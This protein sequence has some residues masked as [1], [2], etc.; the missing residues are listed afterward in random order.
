MTKTIKHQFSFPHPPA[1]VWEYLTRSDLM[2]LWLMKN[3][4]QP[5][6]GFEFQFTTK[7][8]PSLDFNGICY[9]KVLTLEPYKKL[10]YTWTGGPG[11]GEITLD[12][13]VE[14]ELKPT[15]KGTDLFLEHSGFSKGEHVNFYPGMNDGWLKQVQKMIDH[16]NTA[17]HGQPK[18]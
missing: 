3:N 10:S 11:T 15:E 16:L 13:L 12:T 8:I 18:A 2:E 4:F 7:P 5:V 17:P 6:I 14:W 9:C 1:V